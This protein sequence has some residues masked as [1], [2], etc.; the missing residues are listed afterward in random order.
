MCPGKVKSGER[1]LFADLSD[2]ER[3]EAWTLLH[4]SLNL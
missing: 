3:R 4:P 1:D 2:E